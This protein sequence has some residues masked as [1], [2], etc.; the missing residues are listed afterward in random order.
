MFARVIMAANLTA[1]K[2]GGLAAHGKLASHFAIRFVV[3]QCCYILPAQCC[4][5][6][7]KC[8]TSVFKFVANDCFSSS[9]RKYLM[10]LL[11]MFQ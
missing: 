5:C 11:V 2:G 6:A 3:T 10:V 8:S 4:S 1:T 7:G 9:D